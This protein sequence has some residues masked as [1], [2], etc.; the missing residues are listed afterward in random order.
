MDIS[1]TRDLIPEECIMWYC[2]HK[3]WVIKHTTV[4]H[5]GIYQKLYEDLCTLFFDAKIIPVAIQQCSM[6][7]NT[8]LMSCSM[9][10]VVQ[11]WQNYRVGL[12][13]WRMQQLNYLLSHSMK[14]SH[15]RTYRLACTARCSGST[16]NKWPN[17]GI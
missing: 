8:H 17:I 16:Q 5:G 3:L 9:N 6:R 12:N 2:L 14:T 1:H 7:L 10:I 11:I 4:K 13:G 15:L